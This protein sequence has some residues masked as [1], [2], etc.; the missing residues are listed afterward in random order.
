MSLPPA[1]TTS[2]NFTLAYSPV[3][4]IALVHGIYRRGVHFWLFRYEPTMPMLHFPASAHLGSVLLV[5]R[6]CENVAL[7][8]WE[9]YEPPRGVKLFAATDPRWVC[10]RHRQARA[11]F[12]AL[13]WYVRP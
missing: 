3:H 6:E 8:S 5:A 13:R 4:R 7:A 2:R 11:E 12:L 9:L 1:R 10:K